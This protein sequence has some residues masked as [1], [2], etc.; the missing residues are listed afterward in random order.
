MNRKNSGANTNMVQICLDI[1][2]NFLAFYIECLVFPGGISGKAYSYGFAMVVVFSIIYILSNKEA[3]LYNVTL[4]FYMDRFWKI[5]TKSWLLGA[6]TTA[7][8]MFVFDATGKIRNI[9]FV[10]L[11]ISYAFIMV[12]MIFSRLLQQLFQ[13]YQAPR[14]AFVGTF[15]DYQK[16]HYFMNKTSMRI[17][18]IG[19]ILKDGQESEGRYNV[20]GTIHDMEKI[21][22]NREVD[23]VFFMMKT[24]D[25]SSEIQEYIDICLEMGVTV[26]VVMD[27]YVM[28][29]SNSFVSSI[30]TYP[31]ITYHTITLN[32]Y[33]QML[34]RIM[35]V[36]VSIIAIVLSSPFMIAAAIAIKLDS[37]GPVIF[38]QVRVGQN[39]RH[40]NIYKFRS[41]YIDA[42]ERKKELLAQNEMSG[43]VMFKMKNDPRITKVGKF[44]R[45]TS[46]DELPQLFNVLQGTMSLVGTRPPTLD[47]VEKYERSQWR[48]ISIKPGITGMWQVYGRSDIT[49]F[50]DVV[51]LDLR[52]IDNWSL[53]LDFKLLLRTV[54]V[55][56]DR[57]GAY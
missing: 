28:R 29:R 38:K 18:E 4:F 7:M 1:I 46:I 22:R 56:F 32:N 12:N 11:G 3:R 30:G 31:T 45:K 21:I 16:F 49:K 55:L 43:G 23:Q 54:G 36:F 9:Y 6:V 2:V 8:I 20:L 41:M 47:E 51:E 10:Y 42:E 15:G 14:A 39:G 33:E 50:E 35:D 19:Y 17:A 40:F 53:W 24:D 13:T 37:P 57:K 48:R 44:I 5:I 27:N 25:K 52:Y 34:K 26:K